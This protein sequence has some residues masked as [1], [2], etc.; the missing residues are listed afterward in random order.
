MLKDA[1][2]NAALEIQCSFCRVN[3]SASPLKYFSTPP[4]IPSALGHIGAPGLR[5]NAQASNARL[6]GRDL[7]DRRPVLVL[8]APAHRF[9]IVLLQK[10]GGGHLYAQAFGGGARQIDILQAQ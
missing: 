8:P 7:A 3:G 5:Q 2:R 1:P 10:F 4:A 6:L 9:V